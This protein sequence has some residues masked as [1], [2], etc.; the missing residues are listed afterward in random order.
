MVEQIITYAKKKP[1]LIKYILYIAAGVLLVLLG[2]IYFPVRKVIQVSNQKM[3]KQL[4]KQLKDDKN[5]DTK[6]VNEINNINKKISDSKDYEETRK[7][8]D[9]ANS[10]DDFLH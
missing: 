1:K 10:I 7:D 2:W 5:K 6:L 4:K 8:I 3:K 9:N